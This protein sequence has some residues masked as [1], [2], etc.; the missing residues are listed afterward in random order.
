[1]DLK[2]CNPQLEP[3]RASVGFLVLHQNSVA[4]HIDSSSDSSDYGLG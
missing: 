3:K 2:N 1:M 4:S